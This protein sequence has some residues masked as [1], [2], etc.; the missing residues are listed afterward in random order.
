MELNV[1][2]SLIRRPAR[3][4]QG[5]LLHDS[6]VVVIQADANTLEVEALENAT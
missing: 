1:R 5:Q 2:G 4:S 3:C 6:S